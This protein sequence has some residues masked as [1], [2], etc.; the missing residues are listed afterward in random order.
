MINVDFEGT[1][2]VLTKP[3]DMTDEQCLPLR[4]QRGIDQ[5]GMPF[6]AVAFQPN[7]DDVKA[8]QEGRPI[9]V[10][11]LGNSFPPIAVFTTDENGDGN[12][13]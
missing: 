10:K 4:A 6:F 1:N 11:V 9:F 2:L 8:I 12:W 7:Q 3:E 5:A 13:D